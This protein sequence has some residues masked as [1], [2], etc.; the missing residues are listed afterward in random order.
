MSSCSVLITW[1]S[2]LTC[3]VVVFAAYDAELTSKMSVIITHLPFTNLEE[4]YWDTDYNIGA[5]T[6]TASEEA[7]QVYLGSI[8]FDYI[9]Y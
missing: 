2:I 3:I 5:V 8:I 7:F 9:V 4:L 1:A 6:G